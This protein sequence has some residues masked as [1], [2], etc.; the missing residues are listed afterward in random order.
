MNIKYESDKEV[1]E[2]EEDSEEA[3]EAGSSDADMDD[4][5]GEEEYE[6]S[7]DDQQPADD[8]SEGSD[9]KRASKK[10]TLKDRLKEEQEIRNKEKKMRSGDYQPKDIDDFERLL[11]ANQD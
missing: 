8:L 4:E 10:R 2:G 7:E 6:S 5:E 11:V 1:E 3:K 9:L